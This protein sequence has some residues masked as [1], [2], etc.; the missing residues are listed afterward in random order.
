MMLRAHVEFEAAGNRRGYQECTQG[1][2]NAMRRLTLSQRIGAVGCLVLLTVAVSL[3][4]FITK[5]FSKDIA[6]AT[7]ERYGNQYQRPLEELLENIPQHQMLSRRYLAG[8]RDLK[9]QLA[10]VEG[11]VDAAIQALRTVDSQL[12]GEL[13]FTAEGL[14]KRKRD[15]CRWDSLY[16]EWESLKGGFAGQPAEN[17]DKAHAHLVADVRTMIMHAGDTSNLI[18][19]PD[20]DSY[21]LMDAT[22]VSLPQ[23]QERLAT[24]EMLG[25]DVVGKGKIGDGQRIKLAVA[26]ALLKEADLD[27]IMADIHT[28]LNENQNSYGTSHGLQRNLPPASQ[29][30][31]KANEALL[32]LMRRII[33]APKT[34]VSAAEFAAAASGAR[35][36]SFR[37]WQIGVQELDALLQKR[38]DDLASMR[39]W[40]LAV[41]ALALMASA[42]IATLVIRSTT[43]F[44]R[45]A[46][47]QLLSQSEGIA[48]ASKQIAA[49]SQELAS[50]A[51]EQAASLKETSASSEEISFMTSKNSENS[52]AVAKLVTQSQ[53]K[54]DEANRSLE[55]MVMAISEINTE[56]DKISKIIKVIDEIAFQTNILALNAAVEAARAGEAGM[57]FAVVAD[58]VR[59]LSQRCAQAAKDTAALIEAS[60]AKSNDGKMKVDHVANAIRAITEESVK[61]R[62]LVDD[63]SLSSHEQSRGVEQVARAITQ[64]EQ[65]TQRNAANAEESASSVEELNAQ[66]ETLREIVEQVSAVVGGA[67]RVAS[68]VHASPPRS[69]RYAGIA[70]PP[71]RSASGKPGG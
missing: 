58:E 52:R 23:T 51:S 2:M 4:Y 41:T 18:L 60:L 12:G 27:R 11:Q 66:S 1:A 43:S 30:Y 42:S 21:Y 49:A 50:G 31:S 54:F 62:T 47:E 45:G 16:Q 64:I 68:R 6:F 29:E 28:S 25:Q 14:A 33:D 48:A 26:A 69:G 67:Q 55:E 3:F 13:Q 34:P 9:G 20:L 35:K 40:A 15:H 19:D 17:S 7:L 10:A 59:N 71:P 61:I 44:L 70:D 56:S 65:V 53:K 37:L 36:A 5:G 39:L 38:I 32:D 63:V 24:I 22:L 8:Q 46:S 57:G